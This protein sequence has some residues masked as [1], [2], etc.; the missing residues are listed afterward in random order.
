MGLESFGTTEKILA[1]DSAHLRSRE[2]LEHILGSPH[3]GVCIF[4]P[5][6]LLRPAKVKCT[7]GCPNPHKSRVMHTR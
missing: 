3:R 1:N 5:L 7:M 6:L 2:L 4:P